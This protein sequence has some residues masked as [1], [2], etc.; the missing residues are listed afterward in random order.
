MEEEIKEVVESETQIEKDSQEVD[1]EIKGENI[2]VENNP[3]DL[4]R[5]LGIAPEEKDSESEDLEEEIVNTEDTEQEE[6][7]SE[8]DEKEKE[9][10]TKDNILRYPLLSDFMEEDKDTFTYLANDNGSY[11]VCSI[12]LDDKKHIRQVVKSPNYIFRYPRL[13]LKD[14]VLGFRCTQDEGILTYMVY[15]PDFKLFFEVDEEYS[16]PYSESFKEY[17]EDLVTRVRPRDMI[18]N[19][20]KSSMTINS[21][22]VIET[23]ILEVITEGKIK[24]LLLNNP[25]ISFHNVL[26]YIRELSDQGE[27]TLTLKFLPEFFVEI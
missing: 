11:H 9:E 20:Y 23:G 1:E 6:I 2:Y 10:V 14:K 8:E 4:E 19:K 25:S 26:D 7:P 15:F 22:K 17:F 13:L 5:M 21:L 24:R 16:K 3:E 12:P 27:D 18:I